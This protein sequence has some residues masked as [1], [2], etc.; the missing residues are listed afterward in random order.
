MNQRMKVSFFN[1]IS[2]CYIFTFEEAFQ[3]TWNR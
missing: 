3:D 2:I 1:L